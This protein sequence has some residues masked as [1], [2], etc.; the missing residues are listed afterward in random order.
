MYG[1]VFGLV[2]F[3]LSGMITLQINC[4][5]AFQAI[6]GSEVWGAFFLLF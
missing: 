5:D 4:L 3:C 6:S 1:I 2:G